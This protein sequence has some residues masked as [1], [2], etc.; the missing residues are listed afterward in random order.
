MTTRKVGPGQYIR[1]DNT[2]PLFIIADLG[3]MWMLA[4][5]YEADVPWIKIGQ[6]IEVHVLAYPNELFQATITHIGAAVD[7][8]THRV[9]VR[10]VRVRAA[11]TARDWPAVARARRDGRRFCVRCL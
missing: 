7:P 5:V 9:D 3:Q 11:E 1:Q 6:P 10:A 4:N 2:D 8:T